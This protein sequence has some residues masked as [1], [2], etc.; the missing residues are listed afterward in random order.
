VALTIP[1]VE[2]VHDWDAWVDPEYPVTGLPARWDLVD[3]GVAHYTADDDL[4]DGDPGE[5]ADDLPGYLRAMQRSYVRNRGYSIGYLFAVDWLGG[6]WRQRGWTIRSA[7]N[8]GDVR[9]TGTANMNPR[10]APV[11][12]L[13]D[14]ADRL[15]PEAA[16]TGRCIYRE[17]ARLSTARRRTP[18]W[19][20]PPALAAASGWTS[21][22]AYLTDPT[23]TPMETTWP[24]ACWKCCAPRSP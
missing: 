19:T 4:I 20:S 1:G 12:Y 18:R 17:A 6:A 5:H 10:T 7:A 9:K 21:T 16:R 24:P 14:G 22:P 13:V 11:L 23:P 15:T 8:A 3:R 2:T